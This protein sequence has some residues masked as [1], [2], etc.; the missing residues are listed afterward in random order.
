[1]NASSKSTKLLNCLIALTMKTPDF[2]HPL[3]DAGFQL[4]AIEPHFFLADEA[5]VN[6]DIQIKKND[7][8]L[9]F[10]ECK[11]GYAEDEQRNK[12]KRVTLP[13]IM[14]AHIT[15]LP[16][17]R[18]SYDI[19]YFGTKDKE[20]K[21]VKSLGDDIK[22]FPVIIL[23]DKQIVMRGD[24]SNFKDSELNSAL[25]K[26]VFKTR[27][28][29][30]FIP[31]TPND[32]NEIIELNLLRHLVAK[33]DCEFTIDELI[34][35]LFPLVIDYYSDS[36]K[37]ELKGR[38]GGILT[39][40]KNSDDFSDNIKYI[41]GKHQFKINTHR[42]FKNSCLKLIAK[43]EMNK[44]Q[45]ILSDYFYG[46]DTSNS[47]TEKPA[48]FG[49]DNHKG[50]KNG[51]AG[52][53]THFKYIYGFLLLL[54]AFVASI[55][56]Y[57]LNSSN[58]IFLMPILSSFLALLYVVQLW[59]KASTK[60]A[61]KDK[62]PPTPMSIP[63][64]SKIHAPFALVSPAYTTSK[65]TAIINRIIPII[66]KSPSAINK[67]QNK[68]LNLFPSSP[69]ERGN[70]APTLHARLPQKTPSASLGQA[71]ILSPYPYVRGAHNILHL[72]QAQIRRRAEIHAHYR[73]SGYNIPLM[74]F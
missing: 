16:A 18:I 56:V 30:S 10:F 47:T 33:S 3:F 52:F 71:R 49:L 7:D 1:M 45:T 60:P 42:K 19:A 11:D 24:S 74:D 41:N 6:P 64:S 67:V 9:V 66:S 70:P 20:E 38:I 17:S 28:P 34:R 61:N 40:L 39:D 12:Y 62:K 68:D 32:S 22:L 65:I 8:Y 54:L 46:I 5:D 58:L 59:R 2:S 55:Y 4:E 72:H 69:S 13:D 29:E 50:G 37:K 35:E 23:D 51:V 31:F 73:H 43:L 63:A 57:L 27:P 25:N 44:N 26:I 48:G 21:L 15:T 53:R 36:S 14:N